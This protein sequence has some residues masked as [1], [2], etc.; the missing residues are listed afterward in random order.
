MARIT[1]IFLL[2]LTLAAQAEM[3]FLNFTGE[4]LEVDL[5]TRSGQVVGTKV[6]A[7]QG[8]TD[9]IGNKLGLRD[10]E[11]LV[12]HSADGKELYRK[13]RQSGFVYVLNY[14][15]N[16]RFA[17]TVAGRFQGEPGKSRTDV[18]NATGRKLALNCTLPNSTKKVR[19]VDKAGANGLRRISVGQSSAEWID[20]EV[21]G[22]TARLHRGR[23]YL[24]TTEGQGLKFTEVALH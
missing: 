7:D 16:R 24:I 2:L 14:A 6:G 20:V 13:E 21:D 5:L 17:V 9:A 12:V 15:S 22:S 1:I 4:E 19:K 3:R 23:V 8:L 11:V 18:I 10:K